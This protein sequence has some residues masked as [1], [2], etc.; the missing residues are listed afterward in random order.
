MKSQHFSAGL[1]GPGA[2]EIFLFRLTNIFHQKRR[3]AN[4]CCCAIQWTT[5][6]LLV[7]AFKFWPEHV[8]WEPGVAAP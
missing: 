7:D 3:D 2:R 1:A 6:H 8:R 5:T 4:D